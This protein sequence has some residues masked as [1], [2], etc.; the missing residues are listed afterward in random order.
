MNKCLFFLASLLLASSGLIAQK[1]FTRSGEISFYSDAVVEKIEAYNNSATA[2]L[3]ASSSR[4]EFAVLIKGFQFE[5][6]LMQEHFNENYLESDKFPKATFKGNFLQPEAIQWNQDG[7][8]EIV[9]KGELSIH[10]LTKIVE[11]PTIIEIAKGKTLGTASF[12]VKVAD[13][14]ITIPKLVQ[15]NIAKEIRVEVKADFQPL[16][17]K[18]N[19]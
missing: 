6:A 9:V 4:L 15:D 19:N 1:L 11:I 14:G 17:Q 7:R 16:P 18:G 5:K 12:I 8:Y 2:V 13:Y 3:D 10:G